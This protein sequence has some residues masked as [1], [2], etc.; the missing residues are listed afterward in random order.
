MKTVNFNSR[1]GY[2]ILLLSALTMSLSGC[3]RNAENLKKPNILVLVADDQ[4]WD[5]LS[6][7]D[8]PIIPELKTPNMDRLARGGVYFRNTFITSPICSV[9]RACI[10]TGMYESTHGMMTIFK[11]L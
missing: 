10:A 4:R 5:Q 1:P 11:H 6:C 2:S 7:A 3:H 9:S 8:H